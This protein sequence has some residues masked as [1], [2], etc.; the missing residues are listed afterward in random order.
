[1]GAGRLYD[2]ND[3]AQ[4][5]GYVEAFVPAQSAPYKAVIMLGDRLVS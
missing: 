5:R 2:G 4:T 1:M 3:H